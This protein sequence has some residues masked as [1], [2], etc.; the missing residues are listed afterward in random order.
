MLVKLDHF[1]N[2]RG[3]NSNKIFELP[4]PSSFF[5]G[6][7]ENSPKPRQQK[8]IHL[9]WF[10]LGVIKLAVFFSAFGSEV[11]GGGQTHPFG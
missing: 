11:G 1:P 4:P 5:K 8:L 10:L 6:K 7:K 9:N 3:E 2:F